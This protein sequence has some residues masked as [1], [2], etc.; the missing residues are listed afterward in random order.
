VDDKERVELEDFRRLFAMQW[1]RMAE[2]TARWRAED[3]AARSLSMPDLGA[4][5]KWLMDDVDRTRRVVAEEIATALQQ[6]IPASY[7]PEADTTTEL[8][9]QRAKVQSTWRDAALVALE[10]VKA[11]PCPNEPHRDPQGPNEDLSACPACGALTYELR[12]E[13]ETYG[14]HLP[15]C[16]LPQRHESHCQPG[17]AGHP[18]APVICGFW[19][20]RCDDTKPHGPHEHY[21]SP[22]ALRRECPGRR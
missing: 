9:V 10:H 18:T 8:R 22:A 4:L 13:G 1:D 7:P 20:D 16:S 2:A 15:D 11:K 19:P 17:G 21:G 5:L 6:R 12:P 3:P 14:D